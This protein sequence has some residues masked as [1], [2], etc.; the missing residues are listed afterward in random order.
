MFLFSGLSRRTSEP[1]SPFFFSFSRSCYRPRPFEYREPLAL[2]VPP[3]RPLWIWRRGDSRHICMNVPNAMLTETIRQYY[4]GWYGEF[5][6]TN[7]NIQDWHL[8]VPEFPGPG[9]SLRPEV[10]ERPDAKIVVSD[11][12]EGHYPGWKQ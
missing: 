12:T 8:L 4:E 1:F 10:C 5:V 2:Y 6:T 11:Q 9:T 7:L 3:R